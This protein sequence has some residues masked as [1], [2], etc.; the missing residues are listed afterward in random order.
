[1]DKIKNAL[2]RKFGPL[3]A[4]AWFG[5]LAVG[6]YYYRYKMS[7][8]AASGTGTGSVAPTGLQALAP[9]Q[10]YYD[11][12]SGDMFTTPP[13]GGGGG[14]GSSGGSS[15]GGG[16]AGGGGG[17]KKKH[18]HRK[19]RP[20]SRSKKHDGDEKK[21]SRHTK[22]TKNLRRQGRNRRTLAAGSG[23]MPGKSLGMKERPE[24]EKRLH[25][26]DHLKHGATRDVK[27]QR[28]IASHQPSRQEETQ[29]HPARHASPHHN[30]A[31]H[32]RH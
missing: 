21:R 25:N 14:D 19:R 11:P 27:R 32:R 13:T 23:A 10:S 9:D 2:T 28:P 12:G 6:V 7:G 18:H 3:P 8:G 31:R 26:R 15:G 17:G 24:P 5:L 30:R 29:P 1:M 20:R 16:G 22:P 4:W